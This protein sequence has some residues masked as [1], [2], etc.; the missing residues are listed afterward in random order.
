MNERKTENIV[1]DLLRKLEYY[2]SSDITV[3][4]QK[5]DNPKINKLLKN[6]SKKG[7][8]AGY[9]EFIITSERHSDLLIVIECK[10]DIKKHIS[11][12]LDKYAD[13]AVDGALLYASFLSK[14][15]DVIAIGISGISIS[16]L[17]I[18][19]YLYLKGSHSYNGF[20]SNE[21]LD[22]NDYYNNYIQHPSKF[23]EDYNS[24]L[25][26]SKTLNDTLHSYKIK[27]SQRSLLISGILIALKNKAFKSSYKGHNNAEQLAD[28]LSKAIANELATSNI[29]SD[30]VKNLENAFSFIKTHST[31]STDKSFL[32]NLIEEIDDKL[33]SFIKTHKYFDALGQFYIEFLRYANND[34][35]LGIVLTPPH[36]TELFADLAKVNKDSIVLDTT[37]GTAGFLIASL[38]R[39]MADAK[40]KSQE[41]IDKIKSTQLIGIEFQDDIY[42]LAITNMIIHGDGKSNIHQGDCFKLVNDMKIE[43][44]PKIGLLNPPYQAEKTDRDELEYV[45][46][47]LQFLDKNG[48]CIAIVPMSCAIA[49]SG[50]SYELKKKLLENHTLE[51]VM[52]MPQDLFHNSKVGTVT[53]IMLITAHVPHKDSDKKTWFGYWRNDGFI[54]R[55]TRG[56]DDYNNT[57]QKI[58]GEW[59]EAYS[60]REMVPQ[61]SLMRK[62]TAEDEWCI[63]AYLETDYSTLDGNE[64]KEYFKHY[65]TYKILNSWLDRT[66]GLRETVESQI[67]YDSLENG[68]S[69]IKTTN[70]INENLMQISELFDPIN[71]F[72]SSGVKRYAKKDGV[73]FIP[74]IRPSNTQSTSIDAYLNADE[75]DEKMIFPEGS[76]YVSSDGQGSHTYA[77]VS[78]TRFVP[79]SNTIVLL[80]KRGM[81]IREKLF[82]AYAITKNR[83]KFSYGR[84]PKGD[85][86]LSIKVPRLPPDYIK[87]NIL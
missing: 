60:N 69:S 65:F 29:Q 36:I 3:E 84:K 85:R 66:A 40:G 39:M 56:R 21:L 79:N 67:R 10:A 5:S 68:N 57:W 35:G 53:C 41:E 61:L 19:H 25:D 77:Y 38:R 47:N 71:G 54:I 64:F 58:K 6:A 73:N 4:E 34:K 14:E 33:N 80:P 22:L 15:Y 81:S 2:S 87:D 42:A 9:P 48:I 86:L 8:C 18:S 7:I 12:T 16:E 62:V 30:K 75:V 44:K 74:F 76:L 46:N 26:Y 17:K 72:S 43:P 11:D 24:L 52:S 82:Y 1:R 45:L 51:A 78:I 63:E 20:L 31:L 28:N 13:Y 32:E 59:V 27:E 55:K 49:Q 83:Y 37:C 23:K 50:Y 70:N